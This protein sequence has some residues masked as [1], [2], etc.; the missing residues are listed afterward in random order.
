MTVV[1]PDTPS[2]GGFST[3][4]D[5]APVNNNS[6]PVNGTG[7][8]PANGVVYAETAP[9][10]D[11]V[12][13]S[14]PFDDPVTST[15][16]QC[17]LLAGAVQ[18]Q[19][20]S[21]TFT[22]TAT[23]TG[24]S[25]YGNPTGTAQFTQS[26]TTHGS[27]TTTAVS[28]CS[29]QPLTT[30]TGTTSTATCRVTLAANATVP[31]YGATYSG[32]NNYT[33]SSGVYGT[34][35]TGT[36][37]TSYGANAQIESQCNG[38]YYGQ[39]S[40]PDTEADVFVNGNI[41]GDLTIGSQDNII[42]DGN[43]TYDDCT[44]TVKPGSSTAG[45]ASESYCNYNKGTGAV[46]DA[47]GL[48]AN[49]YVEVNQPVTAPNGSLLPSCGASPGAL[50]NPGPE[51]SSG[52]VT[53]DAAVL[54]LNQ[55]FVVNNYTLGSQEG[56]LIVYGSIEQYARGPVALLGTSGYSKYYTW[57][58]L[59]PFVS[60]P[61]YLV[62]TTDSWILGSS[63]GGSVNPTT[64]SC[65]SLLAPYSSGTGPTTAYCAAGTTGLTNYG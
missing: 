35:S 53:I 6:C 40:S 33:T 4:N 44:W 42:I 12:A 26:T 3:L 22:L 52:S 32:D 43:T 29:T 48:I 64:T 54:A 58:P 38:C 17:D 15:T 61:S 16:H 60:P 19:D 57:D 20:T 13:W 37:V 39:T 46:N 34:T 1:S 23:V 18:Q 63:S 25:A 56:K 45:T 21:T 59:L 62:P 27:T 31:T 55:S 11:E 24:A 65:P 36:P 5:P 2:T 8:F 28:G 10:A 14:N 51:S 47:L 7:S 49:N 9:S 30:A 50:C 41:S